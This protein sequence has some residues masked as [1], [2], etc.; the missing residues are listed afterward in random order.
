MLRNHMIAL[1]ISVSTF[2]V[3]LVL[4]PS[5]LGQQQGLPPLIDRQLFFGDPEISG[6]Q[7]SP[8]G[9]F[10]AFIKPFN[11]TSTLR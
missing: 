5:A 1:M 10:I 2:M 9:R 6:A 4:S 7:L 3:G 8:D 11:G